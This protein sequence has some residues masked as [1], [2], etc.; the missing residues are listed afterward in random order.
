MR[1]NPKIKRLH[2]DLSEHPASALAGVVSPEPDYK[3]SLLINRKLGISLKNTL[4]LITGTREDDKSTFSR[5]SDTSS[6]HGVVYELISNHGGKDY[7]IRKL[8]N[9]DY[10]FVIHN[11]E[12]GTET[13]RIISLLRKTDS[14]TAVLIIDAEKLKDK[15]LKYLIP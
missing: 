7:L 4:P 13:E 11:S 1:S 10:F 15:N 14:V 8:R 9:I 2:L 6:P 3:I 5:F 12:S